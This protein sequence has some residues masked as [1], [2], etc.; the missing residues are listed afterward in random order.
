MEVL[1][2][3]IFYILILICTLCAAFCLFQ[4]STINSIAGAILLFWGFS[5]FYFLLNAP[6]LGAIQIMLW[7]A[8]IG[9]LMLFSVMM[10]NLKNDKKNS[11][12]FSLKT[13]FTPVL[14]II[15]ALLII[16]F[17]LYQFKGFKSIQVYTMSDFATNLYKNNAF[18]FELTG[19]LLFAAILGVT[20]VIVIKNTHKQVSDADNTGFK[21]GENV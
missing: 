17:I 16:P 21:K 5:G 10:T 18:A 2:T 13:L 3:I 6:Y 9:I 20:A 1:N 15:F 19:I 12:L 11:L 14:G 4:K 8:G 7:G